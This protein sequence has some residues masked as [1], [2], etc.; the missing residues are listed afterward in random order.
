MNNIYK[1]LEIYTTKSCNLKCNYCYEK[2]STLMEDIPNP[3]DYS[4][5][6][7]KLLELNANNKNTLEAIELCGGE[8]LLGL[9]EF[10]AQS[11]QFFE[12]FT[13]LKIIVLSSNFTLQDSVDKILNLIKAIPKDRDCVIRLQI[14]LD[15]YEEINDFNRGVNTT[16]KVVNNLTSLLKNIDE[17][18]KI[19]IVTNATFNYDTIHLIKSYEDMKAWFDFYFNNFQHEK[20]K[21]GFFRLAKLSNRTTTDEDAEQF[22]NL[23]KWSDKYRHFYPEE[24]KKFIWPD[25]KINRLKLCAAGQPRGKLALSPFGR[26]CFC[27]EAVYE[28]D[29][30]EDHVDLDTGEIVFKSGLNLSTLYGSLMREQKM[31]KEYISAKDFSD[32]LSIYVNLNYCPYEWIHGVNLFYINLPLYYRGAMNIYLKWSREKYELG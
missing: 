3:Q 20:I 13:N 30:I 2:N 5:Y 1:Q 16:I 19:E 28:A 21:F 4:I 22:A 31:F 7:N 12:T 14:S 25:Y 27:H 23:L 11:S 32:S 6:I 29:Y 10:T 9:D 26:A 18:T 15:G 17:N 8:P 24:S